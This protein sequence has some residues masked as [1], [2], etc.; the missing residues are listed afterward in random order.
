MSRL[1]F[2]LALMSA[3]AACVVKLEPEVTVEVKC[4]VIELPGGGQVAKCSDDAGADG[5]ADAG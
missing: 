2:W 3:T 4:G 5:D 1:A